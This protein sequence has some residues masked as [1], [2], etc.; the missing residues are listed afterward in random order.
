MG[1]NKSPKVDRLLIDVV[2]YAFI[3]WLVRR[4]VYL[5]YRSN[6]DRHLTP[7]KSFRDCLR[8]HI[9]YLFSQSKLGPASLISSAFLFTSTTEGCRFWL[10]HSEAWSRFYASLSKKI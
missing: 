6:Y 7:S 2:E 10:K 3:E 9:R 5:A 1:N 8:E 4:K